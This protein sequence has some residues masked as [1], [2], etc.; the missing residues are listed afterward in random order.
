MRVIVARQRTS[1]TQCRVLTDLTVALAAACWLATAAMMMAEAAGPTWADVGA[2]IDAD[3]SMS[4]FTFIVLNA[5]GEQ[6]AYYKNVSNTQ[7]ST[8]RLSV[9]SASKWVSASVL[10][11]VVEDGDLVLDA[12]ISTYLTWWNATS[13]DP[14]SRVTLRN[15]LAFT[16]GFTSPSVNSEGDPCIGDSSYS[17]LTCAQQIYNNAVTSGVNQNFYEPGT[18]FYYSGNH[19]Q[20]AAAAAE[21][22][23]GSTWA[24]LFSQYVKTPL[25]ISLLS[26]YGPVANPNIAGGL[27]I[28]TNEYL[29]W[30]QKIFSRTFFANAATYAIMEADNTPTATVDIMYTPVAGLASPQTWHYSQGNWLECQQFPFAAACATINAHSSPGK[31]GFYPRIDYQYGFYSVLARADIFQTRAGMISVAF[32]QTVQANVTILAGHASSSSSGQ[33]SSTPVPASTTPVPRSTTAGPASTSAHSAI[34]TTGR[35]TATTGVHAAS[36]TKTGNSA[37][38]LIPASLPLLCIATA[39]IIFFSG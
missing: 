29:T 35:S 19:M 10:L 36:A 33:V 20:I 12:P 38:M 25:G 21:A 37:S 23:T 15:L 16:S 26:G 39:V 14:R 17:T 6:F 30:L 1:T 24:Q 9:A 3:T 2:A 7:R 32:F 11:R 8:T 18:E 31:F 13:S 22:A 4:S 34:A 5:E 28:L 27:F